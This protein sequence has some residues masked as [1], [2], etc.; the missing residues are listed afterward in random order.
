MMTT[1]AISQHLDLTEPRRALT[2]LCGSPGAHCGRPHAPCSY[3]HITLVQWSRKV[4][5]TATADQSQLAEGGRSST[6]GAG[7]RA[8][9]VAQGLFFPQSHGPLGSFFCVLPQAQEVGQRVGRIHSMNDEE[10]GIMQKQHCLNAGQTC[11]PCSHFRLQ[12]VLR[13]IDPIS[14]KYTASITILFNN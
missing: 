10:E 3:P 4:T 14:I 12:M 13:G 8:R 6:R 11:C 9:E 2:G 5:E 1:L 7:I